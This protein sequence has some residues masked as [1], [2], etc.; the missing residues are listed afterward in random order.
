MIN[1]FYFVTYVTDLITPNTRMGGGGGDDN[2]DKDN[3]NL[4]TNW[5][6]GRQHPCKFMAHQSHA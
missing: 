6:E 5:E 4:Y 2:N 1:A 3:K